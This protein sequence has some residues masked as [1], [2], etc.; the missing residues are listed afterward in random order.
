MTFNPFSREQGIDTQA[1]E[2]L[3][4]C[5]DREAKI[6]FSHSWRDVKK[7]KDLENEN[8]KS[9]KALLGLNRG[10]L[11]KNSSFNRLQ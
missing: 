3:Q 1:V 5:S 10:G 7:I 11:L 2:S 4:K 9:S 6:Y 8:M